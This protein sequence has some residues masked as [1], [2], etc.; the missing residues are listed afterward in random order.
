M[1]GYLNIR[2]I[3][4]LDLEELHEELHQS[5]YTDASQQAKRQSSFLITV[6]VAISNLECTST[7]FWYSQAENATSEDLIDT[8]YSFEL[9]S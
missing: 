8:T 7:S 3:S 2:E 9:G 6:R 5:S 1:T 4:D